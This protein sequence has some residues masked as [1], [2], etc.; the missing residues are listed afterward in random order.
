MAGP[1]MI[2]DY[3]TPKKAL[4]SKL[5]CIFSFRRD[6]ENGAGGGKKHHVL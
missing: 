6:V 1:P 5:L 4:N 2:K 3:A